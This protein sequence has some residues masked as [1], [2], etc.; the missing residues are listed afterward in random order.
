MFFGGFLFYQNGAK[1]TQEQ[2]FEK[3]VAEIMQIQKE[4]HLSDVDMCNFLCISLENW[5]RVK[6]LE[7]IPGVF[8]LITFI[9]SVRRPLHSLL[10]VR[11]PKVKR[12]TNTRRRQ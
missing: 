11:A 4:E 8:H 6:R 9:M 1:M 5:D 2:F 10:W 3:L 12:N 7:R